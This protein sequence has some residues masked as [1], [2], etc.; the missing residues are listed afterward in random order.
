[1]KT[2]TRLNKV[3]VLTG[4]FAFAL[5]A[6]LSTVN[7]NDQ[8]TTEVESQNSRTKQDYYSQIGQGSPESVKATGAISVQTTTSVSDAASSA[9]NVVNVTAQNVR[10]ETNAEIAELKK[11]LANAGGGEVTTKD[12]VVNEGHID[13]F[14]NKELKVTSYTSTQCNKNGTMCSGGSPHESFICASHMANTYRVTYN[15]G[16]EIDR[17]KIS[18]TRVISK[19]QFYGFNDTSWLWKN[20]YKDATA[21]RSWCK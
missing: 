7:A 10:N 15:N 5:M 14:K 12:I 13:M 16:T 20:G 3:A 11:K 21:A 2:G 18:G 8:F 19:K 4:G 17:R 6:S 1:M 9:Q